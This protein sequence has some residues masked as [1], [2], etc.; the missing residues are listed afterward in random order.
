MTTENNHE[1][2][3]QTVVTSRIKAIKQPY[4]G[5]IPTKSLKERQ[6]T[7]RPELHP[8]GDENI[9]PT[10][11]GTVVDLLIRLCLA[12]DSSDTYRFLL[13]VAYRYGMANDCLRMIESVSKGLD[14]LMGNCIR[15]AVRLSA[16]ESSYRSGMFVDPY[17]ISEPDPKTIENIREMVT[18]GILM[19]KELTQNNGKGFKMG[20]SVWG[21]GRES[22][23][24][25]A[26][27]IF[28]GDGDLLTN[29][30]IYDYKVSKKK[31]NK[32]HTLQLL[33]Y[34]QMLK[35]NEEVNKGYHYDDIKELGIIN[36]RLATMYTI[37]VRNIDQEIIDIVNKDVIGYDV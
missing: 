33:I 2:P 12:E 8:M 29:Y 15:E 16:F 6:L 9:A 36:P 25:T 5:Y 10:T 37:N 11:M 34:W 14:E 4:G 26:K 31:P 3:Q 18:R 19:T 13:T 35:Y 24:K 1:E 22:A 20:F 23:D 27:Y 21:D 7:G 30:G 28:L 32:N 17:S